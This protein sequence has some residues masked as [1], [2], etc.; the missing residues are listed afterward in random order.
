MSN[1]CKSLLV[2]V[3]G[4][5]M[6]IPGPAL[7]RDP[8]HGA[9]FFDEAAIGA[10]V[11]DAVQVL[12]ARVAIFQPES[13]SFD[14]AKTFT[15]FLPGSEVVHSFWLSSF[16]RD[17]TRANLMSAS[18]VLASGFVS[19]RIPNGGGMSSPPATSLEDGIQMALTADSGLQPGI[20]AC[21]LA[22]LAI[23]ALTIF[24]RR[25]GP[26]PII[27]AQSSPEFQ[28]ADNADV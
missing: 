22:A 23:A 20:G 12:Q 14:R 4:G 3:V 6:A 7:S 19:G 16:E 1:A 13:P 15:A 2:I 21:F 25:G 10:A 11:P 18:T 5:L 9:T 24:R 26:A 27:S 28:I 17:V 8:A